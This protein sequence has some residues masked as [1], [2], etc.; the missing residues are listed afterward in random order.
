MALVIYIAALLTGRNNLWYN[1]NKLIMKEL[2]VNVMSPARAQLFMTYAAYIARDLGLTVKYL[3]V[4]TPPT[5]SLG[6]PG[7]LNAA[8]TV[9]Q[10]GY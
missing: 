6:L 4:L 3:Y 1:Y 2:L 8:A 9:N 5:S 7:S 10:R